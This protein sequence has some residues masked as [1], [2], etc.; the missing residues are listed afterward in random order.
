MEQNQQFMMELQQK[1]KEARYRFEMDNEVKRHEL[2]QYKVNGQILT[3]EQLKGAIEQSGMT[4]EQFQQEVAV[5]EIPT[6]IFDIN[7]MTQD[8]DLDLVYDVD[9]NADRDKELRANR[10]LQLAGMGKLTTKRLLID[11]DYPDAD[12]VAMEA[13]QMNQVLQMGNTVMENPDLYALV[14]Q[15]LAVL[16]TGGSIKPEEKKKEGAK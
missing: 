14:Q 15:A 5:E 10:A 4:P 12:S 13:D 3:P 16:Q 2:V 11:L 7:D 6:V 1:V 8:A 9:F